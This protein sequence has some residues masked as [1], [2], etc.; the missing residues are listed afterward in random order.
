MRCVLCRLCYVWE[1]LA[2]LCQPVFLLDHSV[3]AVFNAPFVPPTHGW[4][5]KY[6]RIYWGIHLQT[7][8]FSLWFHHSALELIPCTVV[9]WNY[10]CPFEKKGEIIYCNFWA[11]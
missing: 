4:Q 8:D 9:G 10:D 2:L 3:S 5:G 11:G 1:T 7:A 6:N